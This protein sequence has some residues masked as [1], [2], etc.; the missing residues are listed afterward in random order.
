M[1]IDK[2]IKFLLFMIPVALCIGESALYH[3]WFDKTESVLA[4]TLFHIATIMGIIWFSFGIVKLCDFSEPE[5]E[6]PDNEQE[7]KN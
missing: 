2:A 1:W 7:S 6:E 5:K 3:R 4:L